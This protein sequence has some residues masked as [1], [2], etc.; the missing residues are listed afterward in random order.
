MKNKLPRWY[1]EKLSDNSQAENCKQCKT[2]IFRDDGT[3][4]SNDYKKSSC[5][6]Y[7][8]PSMKPVHVINNKGICE[9]YNG[10]TDIDEE[11]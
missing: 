4:W 10:G 5:Q 8:Y 11:S 1:N 9:Y 3:V 2:C 6:M 7:Q